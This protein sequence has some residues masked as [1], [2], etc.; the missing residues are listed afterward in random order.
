MLIWKRSDVEGSWICKLVLCGSTISP[1]FDY[2]VIDD[3]VAP[4]HLLYHYRLL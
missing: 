2:D 1:C 4:P 3:T